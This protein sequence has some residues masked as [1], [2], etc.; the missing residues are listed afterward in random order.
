MIQIIT[1]G[2]IK[3]VF[4]HDNEGFSVFTHPKREEYIEGG[5]NYFKI[6]EYGSK[7]KFGVPEKYKSKKFES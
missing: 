4:L 5:Y 7:T 3:A 6:Y 2:S 1:Y